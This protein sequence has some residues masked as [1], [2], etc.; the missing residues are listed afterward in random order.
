MMKTSP[1]WRTANSSCTNFSLLNTPEKLQH[2]RSSLI[3]LYLYVCKGQLL[4]NPW[5]GIVHQE[6]GMRPWVLIVTLYPKVRGS[7]STRQSIVI[8]TLKFYDPYN[9]NIVLH[10][11]IGC[12]SFLSLFLSAFR[13][14]LLFMVVLKNTFCTF[15][16]IHMQQKP[17]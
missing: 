3:T 9:Y 2:Y 16:S 5:E 1:S 15:P 6:K 7:W 12:L 14:G 4:L 11:I 17:P 13:S 10:Y 8:I